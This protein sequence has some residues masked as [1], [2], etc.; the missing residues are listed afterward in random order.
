MRVRSITVLLLPVV[1]V[2]CESEPMGTL[3]SWEMSQAAIIGGKVEL[4]H[5]AVGA[6]V[7]WAH[8]CTGTL[9][10]P[11]IVVTAAHCLLADDPV[12]N[13]GLGPSIDNATDV[14]NIVKAIPHPQFQQAQVDNAIVQIHDIAVLVLDKEAK[15]SPMKYRTQ[16]LNGTE[17]KPIT[18]VGYGQSSLS[19]P[20][21]VGTKMYVDSSIGDV[22]SY[23]FWNF[24]SPS[25]PKNT[26]GGDSG[27][28][29]ILATGGVEEVAG[30]VSAGDANCVKDGW[31]TRVDIHAAWIGGL[32]VQYDPGGVQPAQC[33]NGACEVG[34]TEA[35]CP[36][37]CQGAQTGLGDPCNSPSDCTSPLVCVTATDG[38]YCTQFCPDPDNG[39]GCPSGWVCVPLKEPPPTGEGVCIKS[40]APGT[41]G[42]G[43]CDTGEST[44]NCPSDCSGGDCGTVT[45]EGCCAGEL[46]KYCDG[47]KLQEINCSGSESC[48]WNS[49]ANYYDCGT[50]GSPEPSGAHPKD[51]GAA[52]P[53]PVCGNGKCETGETKATCP[54]DCSTTTGCGDGACGDGENFQVCPADCSAA[55]CGDVSFEGCC[56]G[57]LLEYCDG[58]KL[59]MIHCGG[60]PSCGWNAEGKYYDCG[61]P[62]AADPSGANPQACTGGATCGNGACE[63]GE[64]AASCAQDCGGNCGNGVCEQSESA[65]TCAADCGGGNPPVCGNGVCEQG[66]FAGTCAKD[67]GGE[68]GDGVCDPGED[69]DNCA[70]DCGPTPADNCGDG[71]CSPGETG[72]SCP[73]DC[74]VP[75]EAC[76]D[77]ECT[78]AETCTSC[79]QDCGECPSKGGGGWCALGMRPASPG[80]AGLLVLALLGAVA[81]L[82]RRGT[83]RAR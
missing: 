20:D 80:A 16:T 74:E 29:A 39:S 26:C 79:A 44:S 59:Q 53:K 3:P 32:I 33:G 17:G 18:F 58:G 82:R 49:D 28:P 69:A 55:S 8:I 27:G 22:N 65:V 2:A 6:V 83:G 46:L 63:A 64:S 10:S 56:S 38:N 66:E 4:G 1:L 23:G 78:G 35:S 72:A 54:S 19:N 47:G 70:K 37:D 76:G 52:P 62:G 68:C 12:K 34:E 50:D 43:T 25:N 13:F 5:P 75:A 67:C 9:V 7:G 31:N 11:K 15:V 81:V 36:A 51:C 30:V 60:N 40:G 42:N 45:Y 61:T 73:E 14:F 57:Q 41:C 71:T 21:M 24:T 48:G 77:G